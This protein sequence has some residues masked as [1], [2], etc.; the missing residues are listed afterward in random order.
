MGEPGQKICKYVN[1]DP[2]TS[3]YNTYNLILVSVMFQIQALWIKIET[4]NQICFDASKF[5]ATPI[6]PSLMGT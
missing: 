5:I 4:E 1:T 2:L 6:C 3:Q